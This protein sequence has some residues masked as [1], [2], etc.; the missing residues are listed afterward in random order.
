MRDDPA[1]FSAAS[2][3]VDHIRKMQARIDRLQSKQPGLQLLSMR[4][5][6]P[7]RREVGLC[8]TAAEKCVEIGNSRFRYAPDSRCSP[9]FWVLKR[10]NAILGL[11]RSIFS[12]H[13]LG[14]ATGNVSTAKA[15]ANLA[16]PHHQRST[17]GR[18]APCPGKPQWSEAESIEALD[19]RQA[20]AQR[21]C[22][23]IDFAFVE[24]APYFGAPPG[25]AMGGQ[26]LDGAQFGFDDE[27]LCGARRLLGH[28]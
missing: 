1:R 11:L 25:K 17:D 26:A 28:C 14:L 18:T 9:G 6:A 27:E 24:R 7:R 23:Q 21:V 8:P 4:K 20:P 15:C 10:S 3:W 19:C 5:P 2:V 12:E 22:P 16:S 13:G